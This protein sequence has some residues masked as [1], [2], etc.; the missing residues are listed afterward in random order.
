MA[1]TCVNF[2]PVQGELTILAESKENN[3]GDIYSFMR[4][5]YN[6]RYLFRL[7]NRWGGCS[8]PPSGCALLCI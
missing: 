5:D 4:L 7:F 2:C 1:A 6:Q 3:T 8:V